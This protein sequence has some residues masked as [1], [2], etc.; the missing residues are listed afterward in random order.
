MSKYLYGL[1]V[2]DIQNLI[3]STNELRSI[4]G[5]SG[6]IKSFEVDKK[7]YGKNIIINAAGNIKLVF[8]EDEKNKLLELVL[9]LRREF[10][11]KACGVEICQ[12][13]VKFEDGELKEAFKKL[14]RE[15]NTERNRAHLP[16]DFSNFLIKMAPKSGRPMIASDD[17]DLL[18]LQ[19][20]NYYNDNIKKYDDIAGL[21]IKTI[22]KNSK[23]KT[24]IIHADGNSLG[25]K[26]A[27]LLKEAKTD[28]EVKDVYKNFSAKL[29]EITQKAFEEAIKPFKEKKRY[30]NIRKVILG[31][32]DLA[33]I[34]SADIALELT[35]NFIKAFERLSAQ[36]LSFKNAEDSKLTMCAGIAFC[37]HKFPFHYAINLAESLCSYAKEQSRAINKD[38]PPSSIMFH[39]IQSSSVSN[40][41][42]LIATELTFRN[43]IKKLG[44]GE[45][46]IGKETKKEYNN[47]DVGLNFG[48]YF[49]NEED[50]RDSS[51]IT[52]DRFLKL[53]KLFMKNNSPKSRLRDYLD[54]LADNYTNSKT[55]LKRISEMIASKNSGSD[56]FT[57]KEFEDLFKFGDKF[58]FTNPFV[59]RIKDDKLS[60]YTPFYDIISYFSIT[61]KKDEQ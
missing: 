24:A 58:S 40:Y 34:C 32:D 44:I 38:L 13:I 27:T 43:I 21:E 23:N 19:K 49:I 42:N 61:D 22:P 55:R 15:L 7:E 45:V 31:G 11:K 18:T 33:I 6:L 53:V 50:V 29:E 2:K 1:S 17:A 41:K 9:T 36:K 10:S 26:I 46:F 35:S 25:I 16:F 37:N 8:E 54:I 48:P 60:C 39:N 30:K 52:A 4:I 28:K 47:V 51:F 59:V 57:T 12:S 20:N 3:F 14:E 5:G 56:D